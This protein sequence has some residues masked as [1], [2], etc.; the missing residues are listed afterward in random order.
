MCTNE[1][2]CFV[3][4]DS[5]VVVLKVEIDVDVDVVYFWEMLRSQ[6]ALKVNQAEKWFLFLGTAM[7]LKTKYLFINVNVI[8]KTLF[9]SDIHILS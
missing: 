3:K 1:M 2:F 8:R 5:L 6:V 7:N 4:R 9:G